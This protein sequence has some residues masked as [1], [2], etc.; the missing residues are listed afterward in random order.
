MSPRRCGCCSRSACFHDQNRALGRTTRPATG[1]SSGCLLS[2][3]GQRC[4]RRARSSLAPAVVGRERDDPRAGDCRAAP[5]DRSRAGVRELPRRPARF[6]EPIP[7]DRGR[8][9]HR[10]RYLH[11]PRGHR[12][13]AEACGAVE[14]GGLTAAAG[15]SPPAISSSR[16]ASAPT[17]H[18]VTSGQGPTA[19]HGARTRILTCMRVVFVLVLALGACGADR[20]PRNPTPTQI[21]NPRCSVAS[22]CGGGWRWDGLGCTPV[23]PPFC[24]CVCE[25]TPIESFATK[26]ECREAHAVRGTI[27]RGPDGSARELTA[28]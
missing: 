28:P 17:P 21:V 9:Q 13:Q 2:D 8:M 18:H 16:H 12:R 6:R 4:P 14:R 10:A 24:G 26:E 19:N 22:C 15:T 11:H 5:R 27:G 20:K 7:G 1:E 3:A 25:R 23:V